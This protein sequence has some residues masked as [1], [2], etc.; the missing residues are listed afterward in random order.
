MKAIKSILQEIAIFTKA[1]RCLIANFHS[2][3]ILDP[4]VIHN[5]KVF[6]VYKE[7]CEP[8]ISSVKEI[9]KNKSLSILRGEF[10]YYNKEGILFVRKDSGLPPSCVKHLNKI[11]TYLLINKLIY[12][13]VEEYK[14]IVGILSLHYCNLSKQN[15]NCIEE[16][17]FNKSYSAFLDSKAQLLSNYL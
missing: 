14:T 7:Y 17:S 3:D 10:P 16:D 13:N 11:D 5:E 1:D 6:S 9:I 8:N 15:K 12:F 2:L 4:F